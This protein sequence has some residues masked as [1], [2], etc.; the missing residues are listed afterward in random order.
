MDYHIYPGVPPDLPPW[1]IRHLHRLR[2][3]GGIMIVSPPVIKLVFDNLMHRSME[4]LSLYTI[5]KTS[6]GC[7]IE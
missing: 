2:C 6:S 5:R 7:L 1:L 4:N 3:V